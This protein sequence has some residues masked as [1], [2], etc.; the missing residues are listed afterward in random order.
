MNLARLAATLSM[1]RPQPSYTAKE[2]NNGSIDLGSP[3][4]RP[5]PGERPQ[6]TYRG[7]LP[8]NVDLDQLKAMVEAQRKH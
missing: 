7:G 5:K 1:V 4:M 8:V 6:S 2:G 3:E